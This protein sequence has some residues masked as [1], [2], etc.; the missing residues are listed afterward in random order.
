M[1]LCSMHDLC[2]SFLV[3]VSLYI[4]LVS[5]PV[6]LLFDEFTYFFGDSL[7]ALLAQS[8]DDIDTRVAQ[9]K[10]EDDAE[11]QKMDDSVRVLS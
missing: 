3:N 1:Y 5:I 7:Q 4:F 8:N 11:F 9:R 6:H 2:S 10:D